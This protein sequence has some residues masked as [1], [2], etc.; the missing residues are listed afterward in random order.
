MFI[1]QTGRS[2]PLDVSEQGARVAP[3]ILHIGSLRLSE[4]NS[5]GSEI[6]LSYIYIVSLFHQ[7]TVSILYL[8]DTT[9]HT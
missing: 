2:S 4:I 7:M 1:V 3:S 8:G 6:V 9:I 5:L